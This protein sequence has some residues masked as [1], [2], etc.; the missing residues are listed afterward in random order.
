MD[1]QLIAEASMGI[2]D[3][4]NEAPFSDGELISVGIVAIVE[5]DGFT[6]TRTYTTDKI[7]HHALGL[8]R[9]GFLTIQNGHLPDDDD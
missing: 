4:I 1:N 5:K 9:E 2:M 3:S 6:F 7:Y 8:M